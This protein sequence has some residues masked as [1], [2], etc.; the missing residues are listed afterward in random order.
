[1]RRKSNKRAIYIR[2]NVLRTIMKNALLLFLLPITLGS[3]QE[4]EGG[5]TQ[6]T[7][8]PQTWQLVKFTASWT[9]MVSTGAALPWQE[10]YVF[11]ADSTFTK[12][13]TQNGQLANASGTFSM[14]TAAAGQYTILT[15]NAANTLLGTCT[16]RELQEHLLIKASDTLVNTWQ[17]CDGPRLEYEK[18][19]QAGQ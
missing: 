8:Y 2:Y 14:R 12:T 9:N 13:R 11:R 19:A 6:A 5:A 16:P 10:T 17:A 3:C 4:E 15:Y 18:V 1:M 7:P